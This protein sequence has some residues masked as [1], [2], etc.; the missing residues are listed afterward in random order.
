MTWILSSLSIIIFL[1]V[2]AVAHSLLAAY[3]VKAWARRVFGPQ[4]DRW[5]RLVYNIIAVVTLLPILPMIALLPA[6]TLYVT[7]SPWRWLLVG[8]QLLAGFGLVLSLLQTGP[9]HFLGL[10]QLLAQNPT[11]TG[12]LTVRGLYGWMRHP[13]YSFSIL[14]LWL[15]PVMTTN[16]LSV[17]IVFTLYFYLG[18]IFEERRLLAEFGPAYQDYQQ[19]VSRFIP[20]KK[21]AQVRHNGQ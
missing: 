17:N 4:T 10:T 11:A 9:L 8:G 5:Y 21:E 14:F 3:A 12:D 1:G 2:Y 6:Q 7:P 15:S 13:L 18:S 20:L 19:Q 16:L